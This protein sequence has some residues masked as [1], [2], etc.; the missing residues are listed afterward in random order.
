LVGAWD[1]TA[2]FKRNDKWTAFN[3][4]QGT[5]E[6]TLR[7]FSDGKYSGTLNETSKIQG[8]LFK[9]ESSLRGVREMRG[10]KIWDK[11]TYSAANNATM[12]GQ[13][14]DHGIANKLMSEFRNA[15]PDKM[16][17]LSTI[18]EFSS[19]RLVTTDEDG[20]KVICTRKI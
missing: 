19:T 20:V 13:V 4:A 3:D 15:E 10:D 14:V 1:C 2:T 17:G 5:I 6:G 16:E 18:D 11:T 12:N 7:Y 9:V 8:D